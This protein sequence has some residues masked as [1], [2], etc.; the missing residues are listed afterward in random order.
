M[1]LSLNPYG[2]PLMTKTFVILLS[3][4]EVVLIEMMKMRVCRFCIYYILY[5]GKLKISKISC[6]NVCKTMHFEPLLCKPVH[7]TK[8]KTC[9]RGQCI[10][11]K[12]V[13][14]NAKHAPGVSACFVILCVILQNMH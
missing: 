4:L 10:H 1:K 2:W 7:M 3:F 12:F 8:N 9:S 5:A 6:V 14:K 13:F 11:S